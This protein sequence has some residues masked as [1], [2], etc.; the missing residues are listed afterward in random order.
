MKKRTNVTRRS[1]PRNRFARRAFLCKAAGL[2]VA[3]SILKSA[4]ANDR[5]RL[6]LIGAGGRGSTLMGQVASLRN[7]VNAEVAAI[8]DVWRV[9]LEQAARKARKQFATQIKT[10]TRFGELLSWE[11]IDAVIIATPDFGHSP[12]LKAA[13]EAG[14]DAY[15]EKPMCYEIEEA[16]E[17]RDAVRRNN[18]VVQVGTQRRSDGYHMAACEII[19]S[20]VLGKISRVSAAMNFNHAR[21]LRD[22]RNCKEKDVDWD[23]YLFNRPKRPFDPRLL[24]RWHLFREFTNGISGLWMSHFVDAV[25]WIMDDPFPQSSVASGGV[26]VWKEDRQTSDTFH[27]L[28]AF[29][30]EFLFSF[31]MGLGNSGGTHF[32]VRGTNGSLD[33]LKWVLSG[34]GGAGGKVIKKAVKITPKPSMHHM[35]NFLECV[36]S[37]KRPVADIEAGWRHSVACVMTARALWTG[38]RQLFDPET[39]QIKEG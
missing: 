21:W 20:G 2:A 9:N 15:V 26:Y 35:K 10:T 4:G 22:Y 30:K 16:R 31:A 29:P 3:P 37:R 1:Q 17:A 27:A 19:R 18:R 11:D 36:F 7:V 14:K 25:S 39:E 34:E 6:G 24:R 28:L 23:A 38:K 5:L 8:C 13:A 33:L 32:A 12:I